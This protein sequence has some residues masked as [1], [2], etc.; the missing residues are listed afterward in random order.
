[1]LLIQRCFAIAAVLAM[2]HGTLG[3]VQ[4]QTPGRGLVDGSECSADSLGKAAASDTSKMRRR[5]V[6]LP[7]GEA[8]EGGEATV[9]YEAGRPR[10]VVIVYGGEMGQEIRRYYLAT[11]TEYVVQREQVRYE[12]PI[13]VQST[14]RIVSRLPS[15]LYVCGARTRE[16]LAADDVRDI[17]SALDSTLAMFRRK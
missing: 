5:T 1:M 13:T 11:P 12:V 6:S 16:T 17:R 15:V 3:R 9:Y 8:T 14:P 2:V 7:L 4:A 10:V